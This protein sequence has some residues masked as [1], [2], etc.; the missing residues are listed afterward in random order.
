MGLRREVSER[1]EWEGTT[2]TENKR[3]RG[4]VSG[5]SDKL[6]WKAVTFK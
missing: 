6:P 2:N 5:T 4:S 1:Q 3:T